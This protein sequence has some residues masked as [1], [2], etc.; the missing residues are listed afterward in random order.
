MPRSVKPIPAKGVSET[1]AEQN[2]KLVGGLLPSDRRHLPVF[3]NIAQGQV[4]PLAG[5]LVTREMAP[6]FDNLL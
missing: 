1:L 2:S 3:L 5:G 4:E 6:V